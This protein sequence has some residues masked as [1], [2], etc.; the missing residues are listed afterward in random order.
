ML[1]SSAP[2]SDHFR[3]TSTT[4]PLDSSTLGRFNNAKQQMMLVV[5]QLKDSLEQTSECLRTTS[6]F[7]EE[8]EDDDEHTDGQRPSPQQRR[9]QLHAGSL[10]AELT[11][12]D[13][14]AQRAAGI[15]E[16]VSR[17]AMKVVFVGRTSTGKSTTI[18]AMLENK[19]LPSGVGHTTNCFCTVRGVDQSAP[20]LTVNGDPEQKSIADVK[21]LAHALYT[22]D[23]DPRAAGCR[24]VDLFW[25]RDRCPLLY[26]GVEIIDS[27]GLDLTLNFDSWIDEFCTDADIFILVANAEVCVCRRRRINPHTLNDTQNLAC[28]IRILSF[29][30]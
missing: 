7:S 17:D 25:P 29:L 30:P 28:I 11:E 15:L 6:F 12:M 5:G 14:A 20:Y 26:H 10:E 18:N 9:N 8:Q 3:M 21:Q 27:P 13:A 24:S 23:I 22:D 2:S 4:T 16:A 19:I 1:L